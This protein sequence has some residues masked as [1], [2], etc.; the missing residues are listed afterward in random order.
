MPSRCERVHTIRPSIL[1]IT[2]RLQPGDKYEFLS[3]YGKL[4]EY[5]TDL[6]FA[7]TLRESSCTVVI[8]K[9]RETLDVLL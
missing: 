6:R 5:D 8:Q 2:I 1:G 3:V 9:D 7:V 4:L